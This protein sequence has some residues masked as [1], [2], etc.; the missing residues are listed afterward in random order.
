MSA[1]LQLVNKMSP[2]KCYEKKHMK[3]R[4]CN[5]FCAWFANN[6]MKQCEFVFLWAAHHIFS[7]N[8]NSE[9]RILESFLQ[10]N[11]S[12]LL[13]SFSS[14]QF[15]WLIN[16]VKLI[17]YWFSVKTWDD[18]FD[19]FIFNSRRRTMIHTRNLLGKNAIE[20]KPIVFNLDAK[21]F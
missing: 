14:N 9:F 5:N 7:R 11:Q 10:S 16:L 20:N 3:L 12:C 1:M 13:I 6:Q 18:Q 21:I 8:P 4:I 19:D 17:M 2:T 15:H